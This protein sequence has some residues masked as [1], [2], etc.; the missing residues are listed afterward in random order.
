ME[1]YEDVFCRVR[2]ERDG[3]EV[4]RDLLESCVQS[5]HEGDDSRVMQRAPDVLVLYAGADYRV[6]EVEQALFKRSEQ[7]V[8]AEDNAWSLSGCICNC[9]GEDMPDHAGA[10]RGIA[11]WIDKDEAARGAALAVEIGDDWPVGF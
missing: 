8:V 1:R 10:D 11:C 2:F 9:R 5:F 3:R 7:F 6:A 4:V